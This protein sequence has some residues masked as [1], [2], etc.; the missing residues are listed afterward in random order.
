MDQF[1]RDTILDEAH[2]KSEQQHYAQRTRISNTHA[3]S[4]GLLAKA[5]VQTFIGQS[6]SIDGTRWYEAI[7][8]LHG[9]IALFDEL[10][11]AAAGQADAIDLS[12]LPEDQCKV[13]QGKREQ[14]ENN[15]ARLQCM[16]EE[17]IQ[18]F[19]T[20]LGDAYGVKIH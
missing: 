9:L 2:G 14:A 17:L 7:R 12:D 16:R 11:Y 19:Q 10:E 13:M 5:I 1:E 15:Y 4:M 18:E 6:N 20:Q 8:K 3:R